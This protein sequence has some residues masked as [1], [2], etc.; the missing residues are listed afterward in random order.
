[1][2]GSIPAVTIPPPGNIP[3]IGI[4]F[5]SQKN[6]QTRKRRRQEVNYEEYE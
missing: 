5:A 1:M 4:F 2:H 6:E 3:W